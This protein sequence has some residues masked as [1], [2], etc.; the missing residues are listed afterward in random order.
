M[1][2]PFLYHYTSV[3]ALLLILKN[4]TIRFT[5][6]DY[7]ND[8]LEGL[9][10]KFQNLSKHVYASSWTSE[11]AESIP[12][13]KIYS[14][15]KG[16]RIRLPIDLFSFDNKIGIE[17]SKNG[18]WHIISKLNKAY[19]VPAN[20]KLIP[21]YHGGKLFNRSS[22]SKIY[23]PSKIEYLTNSDNICANVVSINE[24]TKEFVL[25]EIDLNSVGLEKLN[26]W[27]F[28]QEYR[29]RMVFPESLFIAGSEDAITANN[30]YIDNKY[31]DVEFKEDVIDSMEILVGPTFNERN[32]VNLKE[33]LKQLSYN[34][35]LTKSKLQIRDN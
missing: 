12:M 9:H 32:F 31:I 17:K 8:P 7:L 25:Y 24:K 18:Y 33:Q 14:S 16:V 13:W 4:K 29:Y 10:S 22:C 27:S 19:E 2:P 21:T 11:S 20:V 15:L 5:R 23:G 26:F 35:R 1:I 3:E 6:L 34:L 30:G 28:E